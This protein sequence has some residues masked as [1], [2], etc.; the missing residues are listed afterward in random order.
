MLS[1]PGSWWRNSSRRWAFPPRPPSNTSVLRVGWL[2]VAAL[3][4][5]NRP[6]LLAGPASGASVAAWGGTRERSWCKRPGLC[7]PLGAA[8]GMPL[9]EEDAQVCMV[10]DFHKTLTP[11]A[12]AYARSR[13][14]KLRG[15]PNSLLSTWAARLALSQALPFALRGFSLWGSGWLTEWTDC[16]KLLPRWAHLCVSFQKPCWIL[17]LDAY[18][19]HAEVVSFFNFNVCMYTH[20]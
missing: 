4:S 12:A 16:Q 3:F 14:E 8:V 2:L 11:L 1:T 5:S 19:R 18:R 20:I 6:Q 15:K 9:S 7:F 10:H 13:G 17:L